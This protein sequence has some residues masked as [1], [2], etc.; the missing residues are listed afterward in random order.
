MSF[1]ETLLVRKETGKIKILVYRK[2]TH[3]DQYLGFE[4]HYFLNHKLRVI[5]TLLDRCNEIVTEEEDKNVEIQHLNT[6]LI[7]VHQSWVPLTLSHMNKIT[8]TNTYW[9]L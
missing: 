7:D 3:T 5:R 1:L 9:G 4:S 8:Y 6:D 2:S